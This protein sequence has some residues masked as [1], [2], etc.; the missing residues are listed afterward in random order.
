MLLFVTLICT[1]FSSVPTLANELDS[2][3]L[4]QQSVLSFAEL[5]SEE[6][7]SVAEMI[8]IINDNEQLI[9]FSVCLAS[10]DSKYGY[11]NYELKKE[12]PI[13]NF[14][15]GKGYN[16]LINESDDFGKTVLLSNGSDSYE[17]LSTSAND[18]TKYGDMG[19]VFSASYIYGAN[20]ITAPT[21]TAK[22]SLSKSAI[23][24]SYIENLTGQY[25]CAVLALTEIANQENVLY[26]GSINSTFKKLW[27]D[28]LTTVESNSNG[29]SYGRTP[30]IWVA[31]GMKDYLYDVGKVDSLVFN[32]AYPSFD[33][34]VD[35][36]DSDAS[37]V[38]TYTL[39]LDDGT[40]SSHTINVLG[41][42]VVRL[43]GVFYNYL[44][45]ADGWNGNTVRYMAYNKIDFVSTYGTKI[46]VQ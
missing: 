26:Y 21:Y 5:F 30:I 6:E 9:G 33:F 37:G 7:L 24:Q 31:Q 45:V 41:Y 2:K 13:E 12:N 29:I 38:L 22:F 28:T 34:F 44:I 10:N 32:T 3:Y 46:V 43:N 16:Y 8:P 1:L 17:L 42:C 11:V 27:D 40:T 15:I 39:A 18:Y 25:A 19:E 23:S 14:S 35:I 20:I 36:I 4:I